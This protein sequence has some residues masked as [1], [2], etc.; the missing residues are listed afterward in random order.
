MT[1]REM[2]E[3]IF[4]RINNIIQPIKDWEKWMSEE[5]QGIDINIGFTDREEQ[6]FVNET[7]SSLL[8]PLRNHCDKQTNEAIGKTLEILQNIGCGSKKKMTIDE[9]IKH[10][11]EVTEEQEKLC[12]VNDSF[13]FSQPKWKKCAE[14]HR[15]LAEWLKELKDFKE[16]DKSKAVRYEG[17]GYADGAMVVDYAFCPSCN[18]ETEVDSENWGCEFCPNCG[19]RLRW[20]E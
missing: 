3:M 12:K 10:C 11:E 20:E 18:H 13:N 15:Q 1:N 9:A 8:I 16:K 6:R 7:M 4:P 5:Y 14:E 19:Q 2:M 17:D